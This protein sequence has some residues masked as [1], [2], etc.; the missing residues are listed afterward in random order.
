MATSDSTFDELLIEEV[1]KY[2]V[3][4]KI[5]KKNSRNKQVKEN[6]WRVI[7]DTLHANGEV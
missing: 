2:S 3:L 5:D 6:A 1:R 4:Y 7:A